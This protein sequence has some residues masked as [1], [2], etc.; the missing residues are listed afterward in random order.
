MA[1]YIQDTLDMIDM[2]VANYAQSVFVDFGGPIATTLRVGG[3]VAL[4]LLGLNVVMQ[5]APLRVSDFAK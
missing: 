5:W 2:T 1:T 3:I 4:A